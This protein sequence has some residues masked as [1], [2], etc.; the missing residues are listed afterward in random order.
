MATEYKQLE[1]RGWGSGEWG[2]PTNS[3]DKEFR[4]TGWGEKRTEF[5]ERNND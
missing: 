1:P 3:E 2:E 4:T 5:T